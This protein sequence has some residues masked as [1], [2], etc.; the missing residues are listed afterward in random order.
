MTTA[1]WGLPLFWRWMDGDAPPGFD[2]LRVDGIEWAEDRNLGTFAAKYNGRWHSI[3]EAISLGW[4][5]RAECV[6]GRV[7]PNG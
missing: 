5:R 2:A 3:S 4:I 7:I 6:G 1:A